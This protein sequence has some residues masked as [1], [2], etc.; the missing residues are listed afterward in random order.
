VCG[1]FF[2]YCDLSPLFFYRMKQVFI[3][4]F[5][6]LG[7]CVCVCVCVCFGGGAVVRSKEIVFCLIFVAFVANVANTYNGIL[8]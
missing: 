6:Y 3:Y 7:L 1:F 8:V 2:L 4:L 5:I